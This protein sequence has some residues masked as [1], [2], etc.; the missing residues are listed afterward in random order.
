[1]LNL[2]VQ[3]ASA[4]QKTDIMIVV[5]DVF[6]GSHDFAKSIKCSFVSS[7]NA[8]LQIG[9]TTTA[10]RMHIRSSPVL[11]KMHGIIQPGRF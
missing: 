6:R 8:K 11:S 10:N 2:P 5:S 4:K 1:M 3:I 7:Q 9:M